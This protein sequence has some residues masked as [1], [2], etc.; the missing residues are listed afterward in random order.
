MAKKWDV[1]MKDEK[2]RVELDDGLHEGKIISVRLIDEEESKSG[3][4][5]FLW[6]IETKEGAFPVRTTLLKGKRWLLKQL[7]SACGIESKE[8]DPDKKYAFGESDVVGRQVILKIK[9]KEST[10]TGKSGE[11]ITTTK[12]EVVGISGIVPKG[13]KEIP[14]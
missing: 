4:P 1:S 10:F 13:S 7:L 3:N 12:P 14:F 8:D 2:E 11:P 6:S 9:N 5:Y